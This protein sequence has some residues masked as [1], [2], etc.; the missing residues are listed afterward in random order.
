MAFHDNAN[1]NPFSLAFYRGHYDVAA[2]ILEIVHLQYSPEE[3][4]KTR[5]RMKHSDEEEEYDS[6]YDSEAEED[7]DDSEPAITAELVD[8]RVTFENVG[9]VSMKV[10]SKTK[11][12]EVL[13]WACQNYAE[14]NQIPR[15]P[16]NVLMS[17]IR[18]NDCKGLKFLLD[19]GAQYCAK[20]QESQEEDE[21]SRLFS[22][23][24]QEFVY[25]LQH[26]SIEL[27]TEIIRRTGAGMPLDHLVE[28]SGVELVE[29]PRYYQGLTVYGKKRQ[30]WADAQRGVHTKQSGGTTT[31]PLLTVA[32]AGRI[33][34]VEW[35]LSDTPLRLYLEFGKSKAAVKDKRL[36][37]LSQAPGG[38]EGA[39]STWLDNQRDRII[40]AAVLARPC[41]RNNALAAYLIKTCPDMINAKSEEDVT[42]LMVAAKLGRIEIARM[43]ITAGADPTMRN[44]RRENLLHL[45]LRHGPTPEK[46]DDFL[47][48][49]PH[50]VVQRLAHERDSHHDGG[51][52]PLHRWLAEHT[53][54]QALAVLA[55]LLKRTG[56]AE[57]DYL[58][59]AGDTILHTLV[60]RSDYNLDVVRAVIDARPSLLHRENAV[61]RT[62]V[63]VARDSLVASKLRNTEVST[64]YGRKGYHY[65]NRYW[66]YDNEADT[67]I[68]SIV[69]REPKTFVT[70]PADE[71]ITSQPR[72]T[73]EKMWD[74]IRESAAAHPGKRR[75]ASLL[76]AND[77]ARRLGEPYVTHQGRYRFRVKQPELSAKEKERQTKRG[78]GEDIVTS[79]WNESKTAWKDFGKEEESNIDLEIEDA[80]GAFQHLNLYGRYPGQYG[81]GGAHGGVYD[82]AL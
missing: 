27:L 35:F 11:P 79:R 47:A 43:L 36:Q 52:T 40:H 22:L 68:A 59:G 63:E 17:V 58:D 70:D 81:F 4:P 76:E 21:S 48:I 54:D 53:T 62:P 24:S 55:V 51:K 57:L 80:L 6:D 18:N 8:Q 78:G 77:V 61:G 72:T 74:L 45:A 75:L 15:Q 31:S 14:V 13:R 44:S 29:K 41:E 73:T 38:F 34:C 7:D 33:D 10:K 64:Y 12:L 3:K 42:P 37:H 9:Q 56:G 39:V 16:Q 69:D 28:S 50:A 66:A 19:L 60:L 65:A 49:F 25:A 5:Y 26:G 32:L 1:N 20:K 46:I 23:S 2:A 67:S 71:A 30:D 82:Y